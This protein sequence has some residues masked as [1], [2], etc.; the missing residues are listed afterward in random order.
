MTSQAG[1][2]IGCQKCD[3]RVRLFKPYR[4]RMK[5]F[6]CAMCLPGI[7]Y[8]NPD[9]TIP[10]KHYTSCTVCWCHFQV[11]QTYNGKKPT[12]PSCR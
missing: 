4:G 5:D 10:A 6:L 3:N 12:C 11:Q 7:M 8:T 9:Q 2:V 1:D